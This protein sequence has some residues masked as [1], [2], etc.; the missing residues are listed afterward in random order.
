MVNRIGPQTSVELPQAADA[1][2]GAAGKPARARDA[3]ASES[4]RAPENT[5][6]VL[7]V[8]HAAGRI[9]RNPQ[10]LAEAAQEF[11]SLLLAQIL[12]TA[13]ESGSGGWLGAG[14]GH[15]MS[16]TMELAETQLARAMAEQGALGIGKLLA[17][18]VGPH[19]V[20][21]TGGAVQDAAENAGA[22]AERSVF[23][24]RP[25]SAGERVA[26]ATSEIPGRLVAP[27]PHATR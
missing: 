14:E 9:E 22:I 16:S 6:G 25:G 20:R 23:E 21:E 15:G 5:P 12:K 19:A 2:S 17:S 4:A 7:K 3:V 11:E 18:T 13:R 26:A 1:N 10:K 24:I 8:E 27:K